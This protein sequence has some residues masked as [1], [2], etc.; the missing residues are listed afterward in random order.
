MQPAHNSQS[1]SIEKKS[2]ITTCILAK[3]RVYHYRADS[4]C[5]TKPKTVAVSK[6]HNSLYLATTPDC[7]SDSMFPGSK[8][9]IDIKN[10]IKEENTICYF[11]T[12]SVFIC[13]NK[14]QV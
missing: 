7:R 14:W 11:Q 13:A 3:I 2:G 12:I 9:A 1:I 5:I 8:Y 10:L 4:R 6:T